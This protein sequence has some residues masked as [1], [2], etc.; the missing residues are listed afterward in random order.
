MLRFAA[1][2]S[3]FYPSL[4]KPAVFRSRLRTV[5]AALELCQER[6]VMRS[7]EVN[8]RPWEIYSSQTTQA[9]RS[10]S[11]QS[12]L[13]ATLSDLMSISTISLARIGARSA[14]SVM[15]WETAAVFL[16]TANMGFLFNGRISQLGRRRGS[17]CHLVKEPSFLS[18]CATAADFLGE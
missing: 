1:R 4:Q 18:F 14:L 7:K 8:K 6:D 2:R 16:T 3:V 12:D 5:S 13:C 9:D 17:L 10:P 15:T 11:L